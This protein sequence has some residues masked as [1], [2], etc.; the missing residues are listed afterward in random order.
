MCHAV[1]IGHAQSGIPLGLLM[2]HLLVF[3]YFLLFSL[4]YC[5]A[6]VSGLKGTTTATT[7]TSTIII[8]I[9]LY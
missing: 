4:L 6:V 7:T 3:V 9:I 8:I 5:F 1:S 2:V